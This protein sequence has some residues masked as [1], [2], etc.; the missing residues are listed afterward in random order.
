[1]LKIQLILFH[2]RA[3]TAFMIFFLTFFSQKNK[4]KNLCYENFYLKSYNFIFFFTSAHIRMLQIV[5]KMK[6]YEKI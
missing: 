4:K 5:L 1:M 6:L 2:I 3:T